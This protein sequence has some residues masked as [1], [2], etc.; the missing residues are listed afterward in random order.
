MMMSYLH[1]FL[2]KFQNIGL[3]IRL[4]FVYNLPHS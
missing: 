3:L 2:Y 4:L 1:R